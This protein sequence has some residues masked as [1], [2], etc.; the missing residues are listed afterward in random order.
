MNNIQELGGMEYK[1]NCEGDV[2]TCIFSKSFTITLG[3]LHVLLILSVDLVINQNASSEWLGLKG[4]HK[5]KRSF[6]FPDGHWAP[7]F[8]KLWGHASFKHSALCN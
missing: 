4:E 3:G 5:C 6:I 2:F 7:L 8:R 1:L